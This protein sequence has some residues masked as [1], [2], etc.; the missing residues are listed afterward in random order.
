MRKFFALHWWTVRQGS[1][2]G[3]RAAGDADTKLCTLSDC[4]VWLLSSWS[5]DRLRPG[6]D[7]WQT[8]PNAIQTIY[9][10]SLALRGSWVFH[11]LFPVLVIVSWIPKP[12]DLRRQDPEACPCSSLPKETSTLPPHHMPPQPQ[13]LNADPASEILSYR[14]WWWSALGRQTPFDRSCIYCH[15]SPRFVDVC[16][17]LS[18]PS[19][20]LTTLP[21]SPVPKSSPHAV[22]VPMDWQICVTFLKLIKHKGR[23]YS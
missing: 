10:T 8:K 2:A 18:S 1:L 3:I 21:G 14:I 20:L 11:K 17:G 23:P 4:R 13:R 15:L 16:Q 7:A 5:D 6:L 22:G 19:G 12:Q 9:S